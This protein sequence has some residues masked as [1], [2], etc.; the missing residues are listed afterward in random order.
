MDILIKYCMS[1]VGTPYRYAGNSPVGGLDCS[2]FVLESL[3]SVGL[4]NKTDASAQDIF[5]HFEKSCSL[6]TVARCGSL[7]FF[8]KSVLQ[9]THVA[10]A[11]D[12]YRMI[13][14]GGGDSTT[15]TLAAA[16]E[17][18]A[19]V[20]VRHIKSRSDLVAIIKLNYATVGIV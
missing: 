15:L 13:E 1:L 4:W 14:S 18:N 20:R 3:R 16:I 6:D 17:R 12:Q 2:G 8:G 19:F 5:N 10:L 11:L 9:I 7:L